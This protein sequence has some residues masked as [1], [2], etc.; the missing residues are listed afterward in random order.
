MVIDLRRRALDV[1][2]AAA[3]GDEIGGVDFQF[4]GGRFEHHGARFLRRLDDRIA[5]AVRAARGERAH[6]VRAGVAVGGVDVDVGDGNAKRLG[7]DLARDRFHAL[8][9]IDRRQR[10]GELAV[11]IGVDERLATDRR[12]GS[13]RSDS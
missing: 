13:C 4:L 9:E 7:R 12:R 8:A 5:D 1:D 11:G 10:D 3:V 2:V 6:A